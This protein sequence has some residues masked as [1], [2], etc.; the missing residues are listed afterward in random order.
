MDYSRN[1]RPRISAARKKWPPRAISLVSICPNQANDWLDNG[2]IQKDLRIYLMA[3]T[4]RNLKHEVQLHCRC[5][6]TPEALTIGQ[7]RPLLSLLLELPSNPIFFFRDSIYPTKP[8]WQTLAQNDVQIPK[9]L[10]K[11]AIPGLH[12]SV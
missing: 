7:R 4:I 11:W 2:V 5:D 9:M 6:R 10:G 12:Y 1:A 3:E 8:S